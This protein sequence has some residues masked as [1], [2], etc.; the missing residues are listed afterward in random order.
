[1]TRRSQPG[2]TEEGAP[3]RGNRKAGAQDLRGVG[4]E[5]EEQCREGEQEDRSEVVAD[6]SHK[7]QSFLYQDRSLSVIPFP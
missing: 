2:R 1:M 4:G 3:G 7:M 5:Q 6:G